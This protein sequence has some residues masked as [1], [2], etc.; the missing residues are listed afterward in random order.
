MLGYLRSGNRRTKLI[1][2][3]LTILTVFTF[4]V[5]FIFLAGVGRDQGTR[6]RMTGSLGSVN[7]EPIGRALWENALTESRL[8]YRQ[9]FNTEPVDRDLKSVEQ[10]AWHGLVNDRLLAQE[11]RREGIGVTDA[12]V[13]RGMETSPPAILLAS[14][15]FQTNGKFDPAKYQAALRDPTATF[16]DPFEDML[17]GELPVRKLQEKLLSSIKLSQAELRQAFVDHYER[18]TATLV[19]VPAAATGVVAGTPAELDKVYEEYRTRMASGARTQLELLAVPKKYGDEEIRTAMDMATSLTQRARRG[20]DFAGLAKDYSE[21]PNAD[22]GGVIDRWLSPSELGPVIGQSVQAHKPGDVLD[23]YR[24]GGRIMIFK[25][26]D[27]ARDT[28]A[29]KPPAPGLVK[30]AQIMVKIQPASEDVQAQR[31]EMEDVRRRA[32]SV[33]LSKAATEKGLATTKTAWFDENNAP[34]QLYGA[35]EAADWGVAAKQGEV[36]PVF[37]AIDE[38]VIAQVSGQHAA[39]PPSR[40]EVADQ[41]K[42]LADADHRVDL[43]KPRAD[44]L[45]AALHAGAKLE[46]A[47]AGV[48]LS[49]A[50]VTFTRAQPDPRVMS[51][52]E[53]QGRLW[54]ARPGEVVGPVRSGAGWFFARLDGIAAPVDTLF[55]DRTKGQLT[56]EILTQRQ[57]SFF[58]GYLAKLRAKAKIVDLRAE[59]GL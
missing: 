5:G 54:A 16:W 13:L 49:P 8:Q 50:T 32:Q 43:A 42:M 3:A 28:A 27:P 22:K 31:K 35:P 10:Q 33:G 9:R 47:A 4:V 34:P 46:A 38:Y 40:D 51:V 1:W 19:Q 57:Q 12:E 6:A 30:L 29:A 17:R 36:S 15:V 55:N 23:P 2:W 25:V 14:P 48:H 26:L 7:G 58:E 45:A 20:E 53:L 59:L 56:T 41:L 44:S 39:G 11:A 18:L 21:G 52:P 24:E 37:D